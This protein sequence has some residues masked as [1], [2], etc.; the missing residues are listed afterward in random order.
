MAPCHGPMLWPMLWPYV[1]APCYGPMLWPYVMGLCY[2]PM[3][4]PYVMALCYV[5]CYGP[6][7][8]PYIM[9]LCYGTCYG[10]MLWSYV[11][12]PCYCPM[13]WPYVMVLCYGP[14]NTKT[15]EYDLLLR[16]PTEQP[17][18]K[19][20]IAKV[21]EFRHSVPSFCVIMPTSNA[22]L[23]KHQNYIGL[24]IN[25]LLDH[26][27]P[28]LVWDEA[29]LSLNSDRSRNARLK[30]FQ[31]KLCLLIEEFSIETHDCR[32]TAHLTK[33]P[34]LNVLST[35]LLRYILILFML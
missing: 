23:H 10:P 30:S 27:C 2:G 35:N 33:D 3:L 32:T 18:V 34:I 4:W 8:W 14:I 25:N 9:A 16:L 29:W 26:S 28:N 24:L 1:M 6:M 12:A 15:I 31:L 11:M 22:T 20:L 19:L 5:S 13:L 7:L 17:A 21:G